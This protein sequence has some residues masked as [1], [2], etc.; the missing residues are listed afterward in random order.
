MIE[1]LII[2][3]I[4]LAVLVVALVLGD[5]F[6]LSGNF[7]LDSDI[8]SIAT[9]AAFLGAFGFG[10]A[11]AQSVVPSLW[12][13]V[14]VGVVMGVLFS[15]FTIWLTRKLKNSGSGATP[16]SHQLLGHEGTVLTAIPE[17]GY[18]EITLRVSGHRS[19][20]SAKSPIAVEAGATVWISQVL[21]ATA[22][23]VMPTQGLADA[24]AT[25][26]LPTA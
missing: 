19:K 18:G 5:L 21:S 6:E 22:V 15:A 1:F 12:L 11:I 26:E 24:A 17:G 9:I 16:N 20:Y 13:S 4:G 8:F 3:G 14:P 25:P 2:G 10:G 7:A 23:E